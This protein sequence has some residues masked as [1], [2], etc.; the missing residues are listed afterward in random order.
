MQGQAEQL[1]KSRKKYHVGVHR[2]AEASVLMQRLSCLIR[3]RLS[4]PIISPGQN[5]PRKSIGKRP[6]G[7]REE[8][9]EVWA[10]WGSR[11]RRGNEFP[12][13]GER[14]RDRISAKNGK[15]SRSRRR[16]ATPRRRR[17]RRRRRCHSAP[18][19][20]RPRRHAPMALTAEALSVK[21][22]TSVARDVAR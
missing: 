20:A 10:G 14:D 8:R 22:T 4:Y 15:N 5:S 16:S 18:R 3:L 12:R 2:Q 11:A 17:R 1:S 9:K 6:V 7:S 19:R 13:C 21:V